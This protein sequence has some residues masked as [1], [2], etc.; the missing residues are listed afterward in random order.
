[1]SMKAETYYIY[2]TKN[3]IRE[4]EVIN[5]RID[6]LPDSIKKDEAHTKANELITAIERIKKEMSDVDQ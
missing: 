1:M 2:L 4:L 6:L 5:S 3:I